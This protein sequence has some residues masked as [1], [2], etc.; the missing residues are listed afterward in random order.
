MSS[1]GGL[2]QGPFSFPREETFSVSCAP[3]FGV[4]EVGKWKEA[5][6]PLL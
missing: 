6:V 5:E 3:D 4:L 1:F 2:C